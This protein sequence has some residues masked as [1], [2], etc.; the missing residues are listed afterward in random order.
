MG[1]AG[2]DPAARARPR[3]SRAVP[4]DERAGDTGRHSGARST[5]PSPPPSRPASRSPRPRTKLAG[6][7]APRRARPAAGAATAAPDAGPRS[8]CAMSTRS[9]TGCAPRCG[10]DDRGRPARPGHRRVRR[11]LQGHRGVGRGVRQGPGAQH[12]DHR[13]R[14]HRVR[15]SA[16][17]WTASADG[18][19]AVR[20]LHQLRLQPDREQPGQ[21][22]L[23]LGGARAGRA[24]R[25]RSAAALGAGPFH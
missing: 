12:A 15:R 13:V 22:A 4:S 7:Y 1:G 21:D 25:C 10:P 8:R 16:W 11:R 19:D 23:P 24:A 20:R 2:P 3:S 6:V 9:A 14:R 18:R 17:R 5:K